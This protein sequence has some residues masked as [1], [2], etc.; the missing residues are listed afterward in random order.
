MW[1][2]RKDG[3]LAL[4]RPV[5]ARCPSRCEV[6]PVADQDLLAAR[7]RPRHRARPIRATTRRAR[8]TPPST[9]SRTSP[10]ARRSW[11]WARIAVVS[12]LAVLVRSP[13]EEPANALVTPNPAKAPWY[14]LWLQEIV[15]DT[16]IHLGGSRST[17]RSSAASILPG[18]AGHAHDGLALARPEPGRRPRASGSRRAAAPERWSSSSSCSPSCVLTI[19]GTFLRGPY[20]HF[21]WPWEAWPET[22]DEDLRWK[23]EP[24]AVSG[25]ATGRSSRSSASLLV[26]S[27]GALRL[28]ATGARLALLP[29]GVPPTASRT[30]S[31]R[32]RPQTV[33]SGMHQVWVPALRPRRPLHHVPPGGLLEGIRG[34]REPVPHPPRGD[35]GEPPDRAVRLHR[36]PRRAGLGGGRGGGA[37]ADRSSG[38]SRSWARGSAGS[39]RSP[40]TRARSCR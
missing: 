35:P 5:G 1:R 20:W 34:G 8:R 33:P 3:G 18:T 6:P 24:L 37:R 15:T 26:V 30:S 36:L 25:A 2:I 29:V 16:T 10:G 38:R 21:Y 12:I 22:P 23:N 13:L 11:S 39:T 32:R 31:A 14:F 7:R 40:P 9:P 19:V 4:R 27:L 17:A 28:E